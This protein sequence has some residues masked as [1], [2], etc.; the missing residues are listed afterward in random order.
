MA[1][2]ILLPVF[3]IQHK[4]R[5][6]FNVQPGFVLKRRENEEGGFEIVIRRAGQR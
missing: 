5:L 6:L 1:D 2:Q 4:P 3:I